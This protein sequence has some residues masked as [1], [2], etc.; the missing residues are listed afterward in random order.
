IGN[1]GNGIE[2][3]NLSSTVIRFNDF[4]DLRN[5]GMVFDRVDEVLVTHNTIDNMP[6]DGIDIKR[7]GNATIENNVIRECKAGFRLGRVASGILFRNNIIRDVS[8]NGIV[9][10]GDNNE[11]ANNIIRNTGEDSI[12]ISASVEMYPDENSVVGNTFINCTEYASR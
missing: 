3:L 5:D 2:G 9:C 10:N 4:I 1:T 6:F 8:T 11:I 7:G 12:I